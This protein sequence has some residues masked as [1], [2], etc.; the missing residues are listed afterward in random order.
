M[1]EFSEFSYFITSKLNVYK[2]EFRV[3][4]TFQL[5]KEII[6][7]KDIGYNIY[8]ELNL[9][10]NKDGIFYKLNDKY[11]RGF[12]YIK[13]GYNRAFHNNILNRPSTVPKFHIS[14]CETI[15][16]MKSKNKYDNKYYFSNEPLKMLDKFNNELVDI[17]I[18]QNCLKL[19]N[20]NNLNPTTTT[21]DFCKLYIKDYE[22][23]N[24]IHHNSKKTTEFLKAFRTNDKLKYFT[25]QNNEV[26]F[27]IQILT[28][29]KPLREFIE[30]Y[31]PFVNPKTI[32][33]IKKFMNNNYS[34]YPL[35][36]PFEENEI[37]IKYTWNSVSVRNKILNEKKNPWKIRIDGELFA[38]EINKFK[39]LI[40]FRTDTEKSFQYLIKNFFSETILSGFEIKNLLTNEPINFH[41]D[42]YNFFNGLDILRTWIVDH[43]HLS[44]QIIIYTEKNNDRLVLFIAHP[45]SYWQ[46][47]IK[48]ENFKGGHIEEL[49]KYLFCITD[50]YILT[51]DMRNNPFKVS[52]LNSN[53]KLNLETQTLSEIEI[54][55]S[56]DKEENEFINKILNANR[57][58]I[59]KL[60]F[61]L[62]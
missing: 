2:E 18:C 56:F 34:S 32:D 19:I 58:V 41:T 27:Y 35:N 45:H 50:L 11:Y 9:K 31:T 38:E 17:Y 36:I 39:T 42:V 16:D 48:P 37:T 10:I 23:I 57:F 6:K 51:T 29:D 1:F 28:D 46:K 4:N 7:D 12:I 24:E 47:E 33:L 54:Y 43:K 14:E 30:K 22:E 3:K 53:T 59:Y 13:D 61:H 15:F 62:H 52:L 20:D 60:I 49:R 5:K 21:Y 8:D 25:H 40:E 26:D 55:D 44:N